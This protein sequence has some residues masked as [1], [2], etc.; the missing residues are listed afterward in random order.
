MTSS[1][2]GAPDLKARLSADGGT[3]HVEGKTFGAGVTILSVTIEAPGG[4]PVL[5]THPYEEVFL[6][7]EGR[8]RYTVGD[9][10]IEAR[11]GDVVRAPA[12]VPHRFQNL[13]PGPLRSTDIHLSPEWIQEDLE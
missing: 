11:A 10:V 12:G 13:G 7:H 4:G 9:A 3:P 6:L 5:H 1:T 2:N 8:A